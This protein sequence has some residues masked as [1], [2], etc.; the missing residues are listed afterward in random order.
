MKACRAVAGA[1]ST[2]TARSPNTALPGDRPRISTSQRAGKPTTT[3][4]TPTMART[5]PAEPPITRFTMR[6]SAKS[7]ASWMSA[8]MVRAMAREAMP[9]VSKSSTTA[10]GVTM[11]RGFMAIRWLRYRRP[12]RAAW[13]TTSRGRRPLHH[14][15]RGQLAPTRAADGGGG[16]RSRA[17][18]SREGR[19]ARAALPASVHEPVARSNATG[20]SGPDRS[21][22]P[23]GGQRSGRAVRHSIA[24][25]GGGR[26]V[27]HHQ[28][29]G[30]GVA[31]AAVRGGIG[32]APVRPGRP[33]GRVAGRVRRGPRCRGPGRAPRG[34]RG[35]RLRGVLLVGAGG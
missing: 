2:V 17:T 24:V 28:L 30:R 8:S 33:D 10:S 18:G 12:P 26:P 21:P 16:P 11:P 3:A 32:V 20:R 7:T 23:P 13:P 14:Q 25:L 35:G 19:R 31:R 29:P 15:Q 5:M 6:S 22:H 34:L 1:P 9:A 27:L 4:A